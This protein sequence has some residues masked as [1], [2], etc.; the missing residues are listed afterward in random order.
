MKT[1]SKLQKNKIY[2]SRI[3]HLKQKLKNVKLDGALIENPLD[4]FYYTGL[5]LSAGRLLIHDETILLL[6][7]GRYLQ[8]AEEK[9]P[10]KV[11]LDSPQQFSDFCHEQKLKRLAFDSLH[12]SYEHYRLLERLCS[13]KKMKPE[14]VAVPALF[15]SSRV[16]KDRSEMLKMKKSANLLWEGFQFIRRILK[17]GIAEKEVSRRFE[18]FCLEEGADGLAF[19]PI[20]AFGANSAMPH[21]RSQHAVLKPGDIVLIDIG[22][23]VDHYHS[24]MTRVLFHQKEN[25]ELRHLYDIVQEAQKSALKLCRPGTQLKE[26]DNAARKVMREHQVEDLFVHSLGHGIGLETH[27]F[28]RIKYNN[29]D[30]DVLLQS[31][32]VFTVEPGL[33]IPGKGGVRY[34]DTVAITPTG[35]NNFYPPSVITSK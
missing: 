9:S 7:D 35:Y 25:R 5:Q 28:P 17:T 3:E 14:L 23:V 32:M 1:T 2:V 30:K 15:K 26:L 10:F 12:T 18:I 21:Y 19:E 33:Y 22:I 31:G 34:E 13:I 4:L 16:I 8:I 24:D 6:V 11:L 20:I 29:E 27:E